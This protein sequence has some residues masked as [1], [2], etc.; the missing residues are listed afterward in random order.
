MELPLQQKEQMI[1]WTQGR[2]EKLPFLVNAQ[3]KGGGRQLKILLPMVLFVAGFHLFGV[4]NDFHAG[5]LPSVLGLKKSY[6]SDK[7][8]FLK[9][10]FSV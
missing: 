2:A 5:C 9:F 7:C 10:D 3:M 6:K 1:H 4:S 8:H